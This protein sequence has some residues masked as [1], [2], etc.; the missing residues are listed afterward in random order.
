MCAVCIV[1]GLCCVYVLICLFDSL[2]ICIFYKK[3]SGYLQGGVC[4]REFFVIYVNFDFTFSPITAQTSNPT[5]NR[6]NESLS[7]LQAQ[8]V[9]FGLSLLNFMLDLTVCVSVCV[10]VYPCVHTHMPILCFCSCTSVILYI[11]FLLLSYKPPHLC[12]NTHSPP[13]SV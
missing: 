10:C 3:S 12:L 8:L 13:C 1:L 11:C 5:E 9:V 4:M 6:A 2:S 7:S